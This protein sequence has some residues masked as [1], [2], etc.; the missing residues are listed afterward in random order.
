MRNLFILFLF[1]S[2]LTLQAQAIEGLWQ[3][4]DDQTGEAKAIVRVY[5]K[6]GLLYGEI[7]KILVKGAEEAVCVKCRGHLK[8]KPLVGLVTIDGF[9][10][11]A[12]AYKGKRLPH[13]EPGRSFRGKV[14]LDPKNSNR[15][16][17]RGYLGFLF[18][19]QTWIRL[20]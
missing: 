2:S 9:E 1:C 5:K 17:G 19:T 8:D 18:R 16:K 11:E 15:L 12:G 6:S 10:E 14:G 4:I 13:P 20:R 3:T 7:Q